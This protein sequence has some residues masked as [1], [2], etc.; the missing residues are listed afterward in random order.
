LESKKFLGVVPVSVLVEKNLTLSYQVLLIYILTPGPSPCKG[1]GPGVR[2]EV[3]GMV[4]E[5]AIPLLPKYYLY[6]VG[7]AKFKG[8]ILQRIG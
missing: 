7:R 1:E 4:G 8:C 2:I 6:G 5:V 3:R